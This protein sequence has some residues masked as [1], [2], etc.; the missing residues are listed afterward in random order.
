MNSLRLPLILLALA[1]PALTQAK[2]IGDSL[3]GDIELD[4]FSGAASAL[5]EYSG[6][7]ILI[8]FFAYW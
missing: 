5:E 8:E 6:R 1:S 7:A 2:A 4:S 3:P